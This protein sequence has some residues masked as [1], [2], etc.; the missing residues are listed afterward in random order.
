MRVI[1]V[2]RNLFVSKEINRSKKNS[3]SLVKLALLTCGILGI[4][5]FVPELINFVGT[6]FPGS[7]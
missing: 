6:R 7:P 5:P 3:L 1:L 4:L 2:T